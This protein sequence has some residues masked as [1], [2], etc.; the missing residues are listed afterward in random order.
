MKSKAR[1]TTAR[2]MW[3][4]R[5]NASAAPLQA[6]QKDLVIAPMGFLGAIW[7]FAGVFALLASAIIRLCPRAQEALLSDLSV[8]Q[9][10]IVIAW[11]IFMLIAEGYRG[12]QKKFS[13]RTAARVR[14]LRKNPTRVRVLLAP[15]FCMGFFCATKKT[16]II[17]FSLTIAIILLVIMVKFV[18]QPWRGIVDFGVVLGLSYGL[19]SFLVYTVK[20]LFAPSFEVSPEVPD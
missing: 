4:R 7:G 1:F 17:A 3:V 15:F 11:G 20:A 5:L 10:I 18:P 6:S 12:F 14:Y 2:A 16:R 19:I 9:W 13:P 8:L